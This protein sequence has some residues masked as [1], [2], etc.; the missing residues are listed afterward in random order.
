MAESVQEGWTRCAGGAEPSTEDGAVGDGR[1]HGPGGVGGAGGLPTARP[2]EA[3]HPV[4]AHVR[5]DHH[6]QRCDHRAHP[7]SFRVGPTAQSVPKAEPGRARPLPGGQGQQRRLDGGLQG[8]V[9]GSRRPAMR[10]SDR[11][12]RVQPLHPRHPGTEGHVVARGREDLREAL[13]SLR[14]TEGHP[15]R[16]RQPVHQRPGAGWPDATLRLVGGPS[17]SRW[18][19]P[20]PLVPKTTEGTSGCTGT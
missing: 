7:A 14:G 20:G 11:A 3:A 12:R 15:V 19:A 17:V 5:G 18:F 13:P 1:G 9:E 16:Q 2:Q 8:L 4:G 10:A 6:S